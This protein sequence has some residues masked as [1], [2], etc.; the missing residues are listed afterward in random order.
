MPTKVLIHEWVTGGGLAGSP[1]PSSW[2]AEGRA[3]RHA[4]AADF[5]AVGGVEVVMTLDAR[6]HEPGHPHPV[7]PV[8]PGDEEGALPTLARACNLTLVIAPETDGVLARTLARVEEAGGRSLGSSPSSVELAGDK[9]RLAGHLADHGVATVS[10]TRVRVSAGLPVG[11]RYPAVLKPIDGAGARNTYLIRGS[12]DLT[13]MTGL[14]EEMALQPFL[15]GT[16]LSATFLVGPSGSVRLIGVGWQR[17]ALRKG[18]FWYEGG[19]LPAPESWAWGA[20]FD[21]VRCVPGLR[22]VVGVDFIRDEAGDGTTVVEINPRPTTS[23]VGLVRLLPPGA[24]AR[25][26]LASLGDRTA[27]DGRRAMI[28][29]GPGAGVDFRPDGTVEPWGRAVDGRCG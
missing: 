25:A 11:S 4:L 15:P 6:F 3:M 23:Y 22:G 2:A 16:P 24:I 5:H 21:A 12:G 17:M 8:G 27:S 28:P 19:R 18:R 29:G 10:T 9:V 26:W 13:G 7:V 20:P 14:D 1:L